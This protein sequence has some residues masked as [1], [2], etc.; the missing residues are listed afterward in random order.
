[1][2]PT[3]KIDEL[4]PRFTFEEWFSATA[5]LTHIVKG[6]FGD[7][8]IRYIRWSAI[9]VTLNGFTTNRTAR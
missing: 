8:F 4:F 7:Q 9:S 1:M 3:F 2:F 5:I 6:D